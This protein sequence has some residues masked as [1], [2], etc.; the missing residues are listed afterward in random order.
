MTE[1]WSYKGESNMCVNI[2]VTSAIEEHI[3]NNN[4]TVANCGILKQGNYNAKR[5]ASSFHN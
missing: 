1:K 4:L 3:A 2:K 5:L